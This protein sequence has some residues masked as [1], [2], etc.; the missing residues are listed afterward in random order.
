MVASAPNPIPAPPER[1]AGARGRKI[2]CLLPENQPRFGRY[3]LLYRFASGGMAN[4]YAARL[5]GPD[6]FEKTVAI[7]VMH[8]HL[9]RDAEFVR[10]FIDEA[11]LA[12]RITHP[13]VIQILELG[14]VGTSHFIAMEYING[15]TVLGLLRR[16]RLPV[17]TCVQIV[18]AAAL[19]LHAAHELHD[20]H[21][22]PLEVVHRDVSPDNILVSYDGAVKVADFGVA[23]ARDNVHTSL[24]G[25]V[26]GKYGYMAPEQAL[27]YRV[28]RRADVF[29]LGVVLFEMTTGRRLF[30]R[31]T[32]AQVLRAVLRCR[33]PPPSHQAPDYPRALERLV[34]KALHRNPNSRFQTALA[35]HQALGAYLLECG[36]SLVPAT[37]G[38]TMTTLFADHIAHKR[39]LMVEFGRERGWI[40]DL[41]FE[42]EGSFEMRL[43]SE[44]GRGRRRILA[45]L[46]LAALLLLLA[47]VVY[48]GLGFLGG[49]ALKPPAAATATPRR[50]ATKTN[51]PG[52]RL[53]S[54]RGSRGP[55]GVDNEPMVTIRVRARPRDAVITVNGKQVKNPWTVIKPRQTGGLRVEVSAPGHLSERLSVPLIR[56]GRYA[57]AL[58]RRPSDRPRR[59]RKGKRRR[60]RRRRALADREILKNPYLR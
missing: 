29:S 23:R 58:V 11:R 26:K 7:K 32:E 59:S 5:D 56:S 51:G 42:D 10:M 12:S 8:Q 50:S 45:V 9:T 1:P 52:Q 49:Q 44:A 25:A 46:G 24:A 17:T 41:G 53:V 22:R 39:M 6:G 43:A 30:K 34:L 3:T 4:L 35:F 14:K 55:F 48:L 19:G 40:P 13:N 16:S 60:R 2:S 57:V 47:P 31:P 27:G 18:A 37:L 28:D 33:V 54:L 36:E 20:A 15:E 21:G 38:E